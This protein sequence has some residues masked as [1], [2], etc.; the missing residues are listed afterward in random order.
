MFVIRLH[1]VT[2]SPTLN[3]DRGSL[4]SKRL[5][6]RSLAISLGSV[7]S[8]LDNEILGSV[9]VASRE[10]TLEDG[11]G[12]SGVALLGIDRG[13]GHMGNHGIA[14]TP[15]VLGCPERVVLWCGLREPHITTI[16][17]ELAGR[18]GFG[19]VFLDDDGTT[20]SVD[21]PCTLLH[22]GDQL[23][24][25]QASCLFVERAVD[26]DNIALSQHLLEILNTSAANLL[27]HL[28]FEGLVIK[29]Q[30]LLAVE[31]LETAEH[32]LTNTTNSHGTDDL[33]FKI[34]FVLGN[35]CNVPVS[36][37]DLFVGR[38]KVADE[39]ED[40]HDDML[41][42][43][44]DVAAGDFGDSDTAIG[45]VGGVQVNVVGANT[46]SDGNLQLLCFGETLGS[47]VTRVEGSGDDDFGINQFL[48]KLGV[49]TL[50][51]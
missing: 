39:G 10:V 21:E 37:L 4:K 25:E 23:L 2:L 6:L 7:I 50:L 48:V 40:G 11:L 38:D 30:Q 8:I 44:N 49:F 5:F 33:A 43:G 31:G 15:G 35:S 27:L 3:L 22:L 28:G 19:D 16:T 51:I 13:A 34:V 17:V 1:T 47:E 24:V 20:G 26:G 29:V 12:T 41:S 18:E 32:T 42:D 46:S 14:T 45:V 9:I 36:S